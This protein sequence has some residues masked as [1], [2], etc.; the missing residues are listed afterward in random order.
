MSRLLLRPEY[1]RGN[2]R[3]TTLDASPLGRVAREAR[4]GAL[5]AHHL[6]ATARLSW[7]LRPRTYQ[8]QAEWR[9]HHGIN[10]HHA[11]TPHVEK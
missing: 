11:A 1:A 2:L 9:R 7:G 8:N 10:P 3:T 4:P 5:A 6:P